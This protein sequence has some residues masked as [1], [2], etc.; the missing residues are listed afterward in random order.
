MFFL[1]IFTDFFPCRKEFFVKIS[2][3]SIGLFFGG[4]IKKMRKSWNP[5]FEIRVPEITPAISGHHLRQSK[6]CLKQFS[7]VKSG[8]MKHPWMKKVSNILAISRET[9]LKSKNY[10]E[11]YGF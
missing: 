8:K 3:N 5:E 1:E 7:Q 9:C 11:S 2:D 6:V 10:I 4:K